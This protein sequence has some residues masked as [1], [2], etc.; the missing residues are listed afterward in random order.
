MKIIV[1]G[2]EKE[3]EKEVN[4]PE[5]LQ[6]VEVKMP[7]MVTVEINGE[8]IYRDDF[9]KTIIRENDEI[10][11]LYFMGGGACEF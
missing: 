1:N 7:D 2:K 10:E 6:I 4:I 9:E 5:L 11:F 8:I 3:I